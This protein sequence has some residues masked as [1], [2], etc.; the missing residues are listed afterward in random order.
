MLSREHVQLEFLL[1]K[2]V[3]LRHLLAAGERPF[4][5]WAAAEVSRANERVRQSEE[6]RLQLIEAYCAEAGF[7]PARASLVTLAQW[8]PEPWH[9]ILEDHRS[10]FR[11]LLGQ[12]EATREGVRVLGE[13]AGP[14][15]IEIVDATQRPAAG[16]VPAP[17]R[18]YG[19]AAV[20]RT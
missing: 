17:R 9:T 4:L 5:R 20:P 3:E 14:W 19:R 8:A 7:A 15:L 18:R 2:L 1:F 13:T 6:R 10:N 12:I 16:V 11:Q